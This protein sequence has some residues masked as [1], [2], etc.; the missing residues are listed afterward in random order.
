MP[1]EGLSFEAIFVKGEIDDIREKI[2]QIL[3]QEEDSHPLPFHLLSLVTEEVF[4]LPIRIED[5]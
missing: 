1:Q 2:D 5:I 4:G 3:L